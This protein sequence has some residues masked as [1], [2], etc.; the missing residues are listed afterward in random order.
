MAKMS[1]MTMSN[2]TDDA[3]H[4]RWKNNSKRYRSRRE[5]GLVP[6]K[7]LV[8]R[9]QF[10]QL[11]ERFMWLWHLGANIWRE[12]ASKSTIAFPYRR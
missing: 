2:V 5:R 12:S 8:S 10:D 6:L 11:E 3:L 9:T 1:S 7:V 4:A